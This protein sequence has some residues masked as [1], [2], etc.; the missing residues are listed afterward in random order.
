MYDISFAYWKILLIPVALL[1][2]ALK[3]AQSSSRVEPSW[4]FLAWIYFSRK[5]QGDNN[6]WNLV[7]Q[8]KD[9]PIIISSSYAVGGFKIAF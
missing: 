1:W 6:S 5:P 3:P 7:L 2:I 4:L 8:T 9:Q